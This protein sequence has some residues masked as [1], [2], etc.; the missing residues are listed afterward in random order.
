MQ[1]CVVDN[2]VFLLGLD[3][4]YREAIRSHESVEL[5]ACA[6]TV[7]RVLKI[8]P[9]E[10][11]VEGYYAEEESLTE[12]F[13]L[14][15]ALQAVDDSRVDEVT[16]LPAFRRLRQVVGAPLFGVPQEVGKLL[17]TGR[18]SLS[19]ALLKTRPNWSVTTLTAE[20]SLAAVATDDY[21][22]VG[23]AARAKDPV[24]LA[25]LRES[26][27]LYA[28][29]VVFGMAPRRV[30]VWQ[31]DPDLA[32]AARRFVEAFNHLFQE[33]LPAPGP[34]QVEQYWEAHDP[35]KV[36]G[37]CVS[38][39]RDD[40]IPPQHYHWAIC[41]NSAGQLN[42]QEFWSGTICTTATYRATLG[43][44]GRCPDV[45]SDPTLNY[46]DISL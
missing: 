23:L 16:S 35:T 22:L 33:H 7:A 41:C 30:F 10:V 44:G 29:N 31:V 20:A 27:V 45:V 36:V 9:A 40:H 38:L 1:Q 37:R 8:R 3:A 34:E 15:R 21:S 46:G 32:N 6:R 11:P 12:Y 5:L 18:D 19:L 39:G 17:P 14:L 28:M 24:V 2:R 42:V 4:L 26:V 25:A 13:R 43:F